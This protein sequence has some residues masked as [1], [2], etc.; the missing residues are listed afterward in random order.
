MMNARWPGITP[1]TYE[2]TI[3]RHRG[4]RPRMVV[5]NQIS[6]LELLRASRLRREGKQHLET[7]DTSG[8][9]LG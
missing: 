7:Q 9:N 8:V 2:S 3:S 1:V 6:T 4:C 5:N